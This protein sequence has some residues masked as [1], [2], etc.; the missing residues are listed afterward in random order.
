MTT[1]EFANNFERN[2]L[3][4]NRGY[5]YYIDWAN[6]TGLGQYEV[7]IHAMDVLIHCNDAKFYNSFNE[8][9]QKL[10]TVIEVFPYLFALAK[11]ERSKVT[12]NNKLKLIL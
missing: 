12:K 8:L 9:V 11:D 2:L 6:V 3:D 5:N 10:P 4:T 7:E 1:E